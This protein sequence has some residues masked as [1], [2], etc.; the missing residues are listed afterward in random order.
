[1]KPRSLL[2]ACAV[3][4]V[5]LI[6]CAYY[7]GLYNANRLAGEADKAER[8]GRPG[9]AR[10]LWSQA[11][12][13]AESVVAR[14]PESKYRDDALLL[15]G[16]ALRATGDCGAAIAPLEDAVGSSPDS[17]IRAEGRLLLGQC[18]FAL[19][20]HTTAAEV[21]EPLTHA[22]DTSVVKSA[23]LWRGKA[24]L[25]TGTYDSAAAVLAVQ[26]ETEAYFS[27]SV[28]YTRLGLPNQAEEALLHEAKAPYDEARWLAALDTLGAEYPVTAS[29]VVERLVERQDLTSGQKGRLL[30]ADGERW[31]GQ[32]DPERAVRAFVRVQELAGDSAA[33]RVARA[34]RVL[35]EVRM[36][37]DVRALPGLLDSLEAGPDERGGLGAAEELAPILR[38][39]VSGLR[40][41]E[42][43]GGPSELASLHVDLR[44]FVAAEALR[45]EVGAPSAAAALF[46]VIPDSFPSS[47]IAPKAVL[48]AAWLLP[49]RAD[50]L[51]AVLY[52]RY[53]LSPYTLAL[54]GG[55]SERYATV[56]D[57]LRTL[58][59][60]LEMPTSERR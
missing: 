26:G 42:S 31:L 7:N 55:A 53:P 12:V 21:L 8:E 48:A 29:V 58:L 60:A 57:S 38:A 20:D 24:L 9:E 43:S 54:S 32:G 1:M 13:K 41:S 51:M 22:A 4:A 23:L 50:S 17:A 45:D 10:S 59:Y 47:V 6:G 5:F 46:M 40:V 52:Q 3:G 15:Q 49:F 27:L 2:L 39:A 16:R 33:G 19:G 30:L 44:L 36:V 56:E 18:R 28:A 37:S 14:Y 34:E 25:A 11:A 35:A